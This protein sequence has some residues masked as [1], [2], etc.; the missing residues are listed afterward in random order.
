MDETKD[1]ESDCERE[2]SGEVE[3]DDDECKEEERT[4]EPGILTGAELSSNLLPKHAQ[5]NKK[6]EISSKAGH[7][8]AS[9]LLKKPII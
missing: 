7:S 8:S 5:K 4:R 6:I 9:I 1:W 3:R 2:L